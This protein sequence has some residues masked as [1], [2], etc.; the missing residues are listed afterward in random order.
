MHIKQLL[1]LAGIGVSLAVTA[2]SADRAPTASGADTAQPAA[3]AATAAPAEA[4]SSGNVV[5][6]RMVTDAKGNYFEP[7]SVQVK[8]GDV[9]RFVLA[10]GVH[11]VSFPAQ[12]NQ[13]KSGLPQSSPYLSTA[14]QAHELKVDLAAGE[15]GFQCDPHAALGMVGTLVVQ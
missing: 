8:R 9:V 3:A 4:P 5:E 15:Y 14:G 6:V 1:G 10:S 2:C 13:G 11:N 7:A 12:L